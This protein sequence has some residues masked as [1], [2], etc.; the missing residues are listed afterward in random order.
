[1]KR[2]LVFLVGLA[3]AV[4]LLPQAATSDV[5]PMGWIARAGNR[6]LLTADW[7]NPA[8]NIT[9]KN[10]ITDTTLHSCGIGES[11]SNTGQYSFFAGYNAGGGN[12]GSRV[13]AIG[14]F[15]ANGNKGSYVTAIGSSALNQNLGDHNHAFGSSALF[16]NADVDGCHA[17][18]DESLYENSGSYSAAFGD[19]ALYGNSGNY[20]NAFGYDARKLQA[21]VGA[22]TPTGTGTG[23]ITIGR[24]YKVSFVLAGLETELSTDWVETYEDLVAQVD[25]TGMPVYSGP[26]NC[27]ARKLYRY[28]AL[29]RKYYLVGT[30]PDNSTTTYTDTQADVTFGVVAATPTNVMLLGVGATSIGSGECV[31]G[32]SAYPITKFYFGG[33]YHKTSGQNGLNIS[34]RGMGGNGTD[35]AGGDVAIYGGASTG[36][37][38]EGKVQFYTSRPAATGATENVPAM[39]GEV[40]H[41]GY[42]STVIS[43][44]DSDTDEV[45]SLT[46]AG[47][48]GMIVACETSGSTTAIWRLEGTTL[49]TLS[50]NAAWTATK[51]N[52][53]TFNVYFEGGALKIQNKVGDNKIIKLGFYG[54]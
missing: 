6:F 8:Y 10:I 32:D 15:A 17:F 19:R 42:T 21:Q 2:I 22:W 34:I 29:D 41:T 45:D 13:I 4:G 37:G 7:A 27:T 24:R 54:L 12:T 20:S 47:G 1:M 31:I 44:A 5:Y 40:S 50:V 28:K 36:S 48:Y 53:S 52:A 3:L 39:R 16:L 18:G 38:T 23:A 14:M 46:W 43:N 9:A 33:V 11:L 30:I 26:L 51:D 35:K 49:V 25:H